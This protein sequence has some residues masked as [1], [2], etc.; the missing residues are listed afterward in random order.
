MCGCTLEKLLSFRNFKSFELNPDTGKN[1]VIFS[2][3]QTNVRSIIR[4]HS[5]AQSGRKTEPLTVN[6]PE[7][8]DWHIVDQQDD[9]T[10]TM[11]SIIL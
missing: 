1:E 5:N 7:Q 2:Q 10:G 11:T 6:W 9:A 3:I 8:E 4:S